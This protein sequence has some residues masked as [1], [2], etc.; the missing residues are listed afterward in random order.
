MEEPRIDSVIAAWREEGQWNAVAL[1]V[2]AADSMENLLHALHQFPG[3]GGVLGFVVN[4]DEFFMILRVLGQNVRALVSDGMAVVEWPIVEEALE[5]AD[6]PWIEVE[7][8]EFEPLGDFSIV[9]DLGLS[10]DD[11]VMTCVNEDMYPDEQLRNIA[12]HIGLGPQVK[13]SLADAQ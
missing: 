11:L 2:H 3:E 7:L 4:R 10:S 5:V 9:A 6:V 8:A 13:R 1:P 12:Q